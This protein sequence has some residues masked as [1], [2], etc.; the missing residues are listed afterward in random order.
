MKQLLELCGFEPDEIE[1]ELPR[2]QKVFNM[3]G[4][5]PEDIER[6]KER[7]LRYWDPEL[8][9]LRKIR[10]LAVRE[11]VDIILGR[12]ENKITLCASLPSATTDVLTNKTLT[13]PVLNTGV[14]GTAI[15][16]EDNMATDTE[17][18]HQL[19]SC[20]FW[21]GMAKGRGIQ[22]NNA[23]K[24]AKGDILLFLHA[25]TRISAD[26][27][28]FIENALD[29][30][31]FIGGCLTQRIDKNGFLYRLIESEGNLRARISKIFYGDQGIF[32]RKDIFSIKI[33]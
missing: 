8:I 13:S 32:V 18:K 1:M 3:F 5:T 26:T 6:G 33:Q 2:V 10:G 22:M 4:I 28:P 12:E 15:L 31:H 19:P 20:N 16:D 11:L 29:K 21:M 23:A 14:S 25:D 9:G 30:K 27:F 24:A 7:I 17:F